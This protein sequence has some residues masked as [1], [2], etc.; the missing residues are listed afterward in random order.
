MMT[1]DSGQQAVRSV[2]PALQKYAEGALAGLWTKHGPSARPE[3]DVAGWF[4]GAVE[5][6]K[7]REAF[8]RRRRG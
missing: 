8:M 2:A 5:D 3:A 7:Q 1:S 4:E 6:E